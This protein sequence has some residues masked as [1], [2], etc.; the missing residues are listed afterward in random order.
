MTHFIAD[1]SSDRPVIAGLPVQYVPLVVSTEE[2]SFTDDAH[3]DVS[4]MLDYLASHKGRSYTACPSAG[5][6]LSAFGEADTVY[7]VTITS[8]LSGSYNAA[9][10]ARELYLQTRPDAQ[11]AVFDSLSTGPELPLILEKLKEL[12]DQSLPFDRVVAEVREYQK[13]TRLFFVLQSL[14]NLAQNGRVSKVAATAVGVLGIRIVGTASPVGTLAQLA[15][16][17]GDRKALRE[18]LSLIR[19]AWYA[20]GKIRITHVENAA[21]AESFAD[22]I[23]ENWPQA[24]IAIAPSGGLCSYYAERGAILVA[25]ET[26]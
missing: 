24:D 5:T 26:A 3:L 6:W 8:G 19:Q 21:L 15:K 9:M 10:A 17:R 14:H 13:K 25:I 23:R 4:E 20:G 1:S 2:R 7:A 12:T 16:C 18:M 11:I 22:L